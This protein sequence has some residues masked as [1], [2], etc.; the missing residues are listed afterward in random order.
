MDL[1]LDSDPSLACMRQL[2]RTHNSGGSSVRNITVV[3]LP[4]NSVH[5]YTSGLTSDDAD[6]VLAAYLRLVEQHCLCLVVVP[7]LEDT[8]RLPQGLDGRGIGMLRD[9][10]Y[11]VEEEEEEEE[12]TWDLCP[13]EYEEQY[14]ADRDE[15]FLHGRDDEDWLWEDEELCEEDYEFQ[16]EYFTAKDDNGTAAKEEVVLDETSGAKEEVLN[17]GD[18]LFIF[19]TGVKTYQAHQI[20][21]KLMS[22]VRFKQKLNIPQNIRKQAEEQKKRKEEERENL[23]G[24]IDFEPTPWSNYKEVAQMF[25]IIDILIDFHGYVTGY[26]V[27]PDSR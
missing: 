26:G 6:T 9:G 23:Q 18:K 22:K 17:D 2:Y 19:T 13:I 5:D 27:S 21:I 15:D 20:G 12:Q 3:P 14:H 7:P 1:S 24:R 25:D 11:V 8:P 4:R 10:R 16:W